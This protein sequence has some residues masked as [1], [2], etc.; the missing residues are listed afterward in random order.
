[1]GQSWPG[2]ALSSEVSYLDGDGFGVWWVRLLSFE[3]ASGRFLWAQET[4]S[5]V[6]PWWPFG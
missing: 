1:M 2:P 4:K 3:G 6:T 5:E